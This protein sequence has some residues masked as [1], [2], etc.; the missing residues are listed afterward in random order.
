[1][2]AKDLAKLSNYKLYEML[3]N[4]ELHE[5]IGYGSGGKKYQA[6]IDRLLQAGFEVERYRWQIVSGK[7]K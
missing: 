5:L 2:N 4:G 3:L 6:V 1:M 7:P